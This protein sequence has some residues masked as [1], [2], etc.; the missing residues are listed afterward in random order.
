MLWGWWWCSSRPGWCFPSKCIIVEWLQNALCCSGYPVKTSGAQQHSWLLLCVFTVYSVHSGPV[1]VFDS[2]TMRAPYFWFSDSH[3]E[4]ILIIPDLSYWNYWGLG[5]SFLNTR[6]TCV[7]VSEIAPQL[8]V[9]RLPH[10]ELSISSG[11]P[12]SHAQT[13]STTSADSMSSLCQP[14]SADGSA[15]ASSSCFHC[16]PLH[17]SPPPQHLLLMLHLT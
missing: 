2:S 9:E 10:I 7:V 1:P 5:L 16:E 12:Q 15:D 14:I 8:D 13:R 3:K 11:G 4:W 17:K 6:L